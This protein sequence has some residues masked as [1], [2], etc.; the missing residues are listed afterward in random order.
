LVSEEKA[1]WQKRLIIIGISESYHTDS[2]ATEE[3][4]LNSRR[5]LVSEC[6]RSFPDDLNAYA[7]PEGTIA[8]TEKVKKED[9]GHLQRH[10]LQPLFSLI[11]A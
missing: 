2:T 8:A 6:Y 3:K 7:S 5:S 10:R 11:S 1:E 9:P 4:S